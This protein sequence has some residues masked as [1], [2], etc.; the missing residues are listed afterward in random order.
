MHIRDCC[1]WADHRARTVSPLTFPGPSNSKLR[2]RAR[3]RQGRQG[4]W[5]RCRTPG[6]FSSVAPVCSEGPPTVVCPR[7]LVC[8]CRDTVTPSRAFCR[9]S[10][11]VTGALRPGSVRGTLASAADPGEAPAHH[12]V[13][14]LA[15]ALAC[16]RRTAAHRP[17]FSALGERTC[18]RRLL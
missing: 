16:R 17:A 11:A 12:R 7:S 14:L 4:A 6:W 9:S 15:S 13:Q 10:V 2:S 8:T 18:P 1:I 3:G 5:T